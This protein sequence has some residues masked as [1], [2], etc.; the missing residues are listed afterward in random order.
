VNAQPPVPEDE[1]VAPA[2]KVTKISLD[3]YWD[4]LN[5]YYRKYDETS[6]YIA[7]VVLHPG[8]KWRYFKSQ[9]TEAYQGSWMRDTK[10]V[11]KVF[12]EKEYKVPHKTNASSRAA[13]I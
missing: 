3:N 8:L 7:A 12:W 4:K 10:R 2:R 1:V 13:D 6:V 11:V 5:K 9:W